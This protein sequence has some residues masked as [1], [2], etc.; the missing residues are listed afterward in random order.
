MKTCQIVK[1]LFLS[2]PVM[3][4]SCEALPI[5]YSKSQSWV[6]RENAAKENKIT[7][8][9]LDVQVDRSGG[10][11]S[12]EKEAAALAPLYFWNRG[13]TVTPAGEEPE[14]AAEIQLR[15]REY[16]L[17]WRTKRSL[18]VEVRIWL[19][20]DAQGKLP[21]AAGRVIAVGEKSF[22]SSENTGRLL[23][24]AVGIAAKDLKSYIRKQKKEG[25]KKNA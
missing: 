24:R 11:D 20:E 12:I 23:S 1:I 16:T 17:G 2:V 4:L 14:Y 18:A 7:I 8:A 5:N 6:I 19:F 22:S 25:Q 3:L 9:L 13:C 15:E 21:V 10:W